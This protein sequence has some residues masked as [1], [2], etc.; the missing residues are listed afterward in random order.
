MKLARKEKRANRQKPTCNSCAR[1]D[2]YTH[3]FR[4]AG[5]GAGVLRLH[6][7]HWRTGTSSRRT[8]KHAEL[9]SLLR[10]RKKGRERSSK[11]AGCITKEARAGNPR[12]RA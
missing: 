12:T 3:F 7:R 5:V 1:I 4:V 11:R 8:E 9:D 6:F 2:V 10:N